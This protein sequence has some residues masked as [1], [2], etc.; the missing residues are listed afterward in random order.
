MNFIAIDFET[1]N[2][3]RSSICSIGLAFVEDG[4]LAG[5]EHIYVKPTPN[6]YDRFNSQLHGIDDSHTWD[7][8]TFRE[9]WEGLKKYFHNRTIVA[10]NAS[11]DCS[12]LRFTLDDAKLAY[13]DLDYHCTFRLAQ[14]ILPLLSHRLNDVSKHFN[15]Q[16]RHHNAESDA[17]ASAIIALRLCDQLKVSSLEELS[18]C[19]GFKTGKIVSKTKS[20]SPFSKK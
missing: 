16:L 8:P 10:H 7:K 14:K 3:S 19:V 20:Y 13:P 12:V 9:Q 17:I 2:S 11:F 5:S 15:I 18:K 1:A 4:K 6:Y